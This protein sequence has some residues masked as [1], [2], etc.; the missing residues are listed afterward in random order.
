MKINKTLIAVLS[1]TALTML[2]CSKSGDNKEASTA[3][4]S[5]NETLTRANPKW[6]VQE[7]FKSR[8]KKF[9]E[10]SSCWIRVSSS[11]KYCVN[12]QIVTSKP[13][14][15]GRLLYVTESG[16]LMENDGTLN[17]THVV[18]GIV[19]LFLVEEANGK[20]QVV[21]SSDEIANGAYGTPNEADTYRAGN[22]GQLGFILTNGDMHQ[23]YAGSTL[24]LFLQN[25][26]KIVEVATLNT[27]YGNEGACGDPKDQLCDLNSI[28]TKIE[29]IN[30]SGKKYFDLKIKTTKESKEMGK[31]AAKTEK[32]AI[33]KF[34]EAKFAY[35]IGDT[36]KPYAGLDY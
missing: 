35:D 16:S 32:S 1:F 11:G 23:G 21:A 4:A 24:S 33:I 25:G 26:K 14:N 30:D 15:T 36:N 20:F 13:T 6:Q 12:L 8:Y 17:Q 7:L 28:D 34:D 31:A 3:A 18:S 5:Q 27:S 22:D 10:K 19:S 9:N 2:A 29:T